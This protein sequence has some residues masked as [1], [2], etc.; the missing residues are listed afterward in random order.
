MSSVSC[1]LRCA[2]ERR[3]KSANFVE[4]DKSCSFLDK[5]ETT[6]A[7]LVQCEHFGAIHLKKVGI[8]K[9]NK[10]CFKT[11]FSFTYENLRFLFL[12]STQ[13]HSDTGEC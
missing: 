1:S 9:G 4:R 7:H 2:K 5:T 11:S 13:V 10:H 8:K 6:H 3:C 12:I